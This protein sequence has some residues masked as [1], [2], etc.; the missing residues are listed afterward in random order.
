MASKAQFKEF[1]DNFLLPMLV[2]AHRICL[3]DNIGGDGIQSETM[4]HLVKATIKTAILAGMGK[5]EL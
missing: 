1:L 2:G 5:E 4:R 3:D